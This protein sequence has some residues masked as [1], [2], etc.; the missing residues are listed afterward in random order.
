MNFLQYITYFFEELLLILSFPFSG[1]LSYLI[2]E[3]RVKN[4]KNKGSIIIVRRWLSRSAIYVIW[5]NYIEKRGFRVYLV[6][7]PLQ[8]GSFHASARKLK[9]YIDKK[10]L[11]KITLVGVSAGAITSLVYLQDYSGWKKVDKFISLGAPFHGT[12]MMYFLFPLF[13][14]HELFP[15]SHFLKKLFSKEIKNKDKIYCIRAKYDEMV[16]ANSSFI[17]GAHGI[18]ITTFG[19]NRLHMGSKRAYGQI[20]SLAR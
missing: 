16:P 10:G 9:N 18:T 6:N 20:I 12:P 8:Q 4:K 13:S 19:H 1:L 2:H 14:A 17:D 11:Q 3:K 7:L 5:K 15:N